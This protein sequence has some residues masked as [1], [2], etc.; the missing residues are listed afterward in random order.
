MISFFVTAFA[1]GDFAQAWVWS[2]EPEKAKDEDKKAGD[3][4]SA[5]HPNGM[6]KT[7]S[8]DTNGST[9][10]DTGRKLKKRR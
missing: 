8:A 3:T 9:T 5:D 6:E 7:S 10:E 4:V 2:D 1:K